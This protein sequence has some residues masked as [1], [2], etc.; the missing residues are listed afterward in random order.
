[1]TKLNIGMLRSDGKSLRN[2]FVLFQNS[3]TMLLFI[4]V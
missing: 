1:M 3:V 2:V 4:A